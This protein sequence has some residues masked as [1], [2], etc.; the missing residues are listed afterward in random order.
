MRGHHLLTVLPLAAALLLVVPLRSDGQAT[1]DNASTSLASTLNDPVAGDEKFFTLPVG[2]SNVMFMQDVSGSMTNIPECGDANVWGDSSSLATCKWP[3]NYPG[4]TNP[5]VGAISENGTC[6]VTPSTNPLNW[7]ASYDP[8]A[9]ALVDPGNGTASN[10]LIDAP[11]WG[12]GCTGNN[13]LFQP[14]A[15]YAYDSWNETSATPSSIPS[16][17]WRAAMT[18]MNSSSPPG[19]QTGRRAPTMARRVER[20]GDRSPWRILYREEAAIPLLSESSR[21]VIRMS[22]FRM[23]FRVATNSSSESMDARRRRSMGSR[24]TMD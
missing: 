23:P 6:T 3:T 9:N 12:T 20:L 18:P 16:S 11:P 15:I 2:P 22:V 8:T 17:V 24:R 19:C 21:T 4:I 1:C 5:A 13:C 7:M 14:T 10:G